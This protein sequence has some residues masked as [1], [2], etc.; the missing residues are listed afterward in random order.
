MNSAGAVYPYPQQ[1]GFARLG[2]K[3]KLKTT[4]DSQH[5]KSTRYFGQPP[6]RLG[7]S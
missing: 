2:L 7:D 1:G 3:S 4:R 6:N 5:E